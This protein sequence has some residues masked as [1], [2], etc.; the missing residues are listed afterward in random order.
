[1]LRREAEGRTW[2][3]RQDG[4][5]CDDNNLPGIY[6]YMT[7]FGLQ[8]YDGKLALVINDNVFSSEKFNIFLNYLSSLTE[9]PF[10]EIHMSG[11]SHLSFSDKQKAKAVCVEKGIKFVCEDLKAWSSEGSRASAPASAIAVS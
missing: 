9:S 10:S 7:L 6:H 5:P 11:A 3:F 1:M 2:L 8:G 4:A